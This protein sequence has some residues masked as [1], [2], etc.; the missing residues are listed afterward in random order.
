MRGSLVDEPASTDEKNTSGSAFTTPS[1]TPV[2]LLKVTRRP[3]TKTKYCVGPTEPMQSGGND[4]VGLTPERVAPV[5]FVPTT[6]GLRIWLSF[7]FALKSG[8]SSGSWE[9]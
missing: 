2:A 6:C 7:G 4:S 1:A 9:T 8:A 3:F 5:K